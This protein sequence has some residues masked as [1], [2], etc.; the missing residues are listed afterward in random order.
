MI[1]KKVENKKEAVD[2]IKE[3]ESK[4]DMLKGKNKLLTSKYR[5][6]IFSVEK[7]LLSDNFD[8]NTIKIKRLNKRISMLEG[9]INAKNI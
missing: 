7:K 9:F 6:S 2:L 3:L 5:L 8:N 4:K 1:E